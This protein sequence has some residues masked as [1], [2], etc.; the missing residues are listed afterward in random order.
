MNFYKKEPTIKKKIV[1]TELKISVLEKLTT[2]RQGG[3]GSSG[4]FN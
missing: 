2:F 4:K 1:R 3:P